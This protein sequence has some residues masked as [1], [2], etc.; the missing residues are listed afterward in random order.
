[1][2]NKVQNLDIYIKSINKL[3]EFK[4][5]IKGFF[6]DIKVQFFDSYKNSNTFS[7]QIKNL[8]RFLKDKFQNTKE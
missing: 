8:Y 1:L 4:I 7:M 6:I 2:I 3:S 5:L